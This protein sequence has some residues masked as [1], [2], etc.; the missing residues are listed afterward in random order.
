MSYNK[1]RYSDLS[2][3]DRTVRLYNLTRKEIEILKSFGA[4]PDS[5]DGELALEMGITIATL[6]NHFSNL[7][8][9]LE[10]RSRSG[11]LVKA[12]ELGIIDFFGSA[13]AAKQSS[14][15]VERVAR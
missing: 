2:E 3:L 4:R 11:V 14:K 12:I 9:K 1:K 7:Y 5:T 15:E 13:K 8:S 6:Y 10:V